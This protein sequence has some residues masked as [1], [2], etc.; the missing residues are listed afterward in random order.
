METVKKLMAEEFWSMLK[1]VEQLK[2]GYR[3]DWVS[4]CL[5]R[6]IIEEFTSGPSNWTSS[7]IT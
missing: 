6:L 5:I 7:G 4:L 1:E 3:A 2:V